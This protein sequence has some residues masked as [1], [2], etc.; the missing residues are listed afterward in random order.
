[1]STDG[2]PGLFGHCAHKAE[3]YVLRL[4]RPTLPRLTC[5]ILDR[6]G[7]P[8]FLGVLE[9]CFTSVRIFMDQRGRVLAP[10]QR[11][12]HPSSL[13][14]FG[15]VFLGPPCH[16]PVFGLDRRSAF[17]YRLSPC[18]FLYQQ[19]RLGG[20]QVWPLTPT[21]TIILRLLALICSSVIQHV[22][23]KPSIPALFV[24]DRTPSGGTYLF[25]AGRARASDGAAADRRPG[26]WQR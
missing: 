25:P 20:P 13:Y 16:I 3:A 7:R 12:E 21:T 24:F 8:S 5:R 10:A 26:Q 15:L 11:L 23:P 1:M 19:W 4:G 6:S 14:A 18:G 2:I 17:V 22:F 9:L